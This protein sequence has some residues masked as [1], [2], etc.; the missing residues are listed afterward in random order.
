MAQA[1]SIVEGYELQHYLDDLHV[2]HQ[3]ALLLIAH[4]ARYNS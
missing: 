3:D 1:G 2:L 4:R